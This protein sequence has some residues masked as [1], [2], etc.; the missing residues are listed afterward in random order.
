MLLSCAEKTA[1]Q[2]KDSTATLSKEEVIKTAREAYIYSLPLVL[3][4][5]TRKQGTNYYPANRAYAPVNSFKHLSE[6]PDASFKAVVRP[7]ADTYYSS[8]ILDLSKE[9]VVLSVPDTKGRY[10]MMPM[11]DAYTN[12]FASPGKRTTGDQAG[13]YLITGPKWN[14]AVPEGMTQIAAPT[15]LVWIIGRTQVNSKEDGKNVVVPLQQNYA[16]VPL[17]YWGKDYDPIQVVEDPGIP[18]EDP[19]TVVSRMSVEEYF[20]YVNSLL[21]TYPAPAA[22]N[23][24]LKRF[25][26]IGVGAGLKFNLDAF[27]DSTKVALKN[28]PLEIFTGLKVSVTQP[29]DSLLVNGWL[30]HRG[31]GSYGTDY[32]KRAMVA[33]MGLG[34]NLPED[35]LYSSCA[36]DEDKNLLNGANNY[37]LH[38]EKGKT[39]PVNAFWSL[40]MYSPDGYFIENPINRYTLGDRSNLKINADGSIDLY[41]QNTSPGKAKESNWLPAPKGEFNVLLRLYWPKEEVINGQWNAPVIKKVK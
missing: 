40:T 11:L 30:M 12:V 15:D 4:D 19:N 21:G 7:N 25:A 38:F 37:V 28:V 22:D 23:E 32:M 26:G 5:I 27:D 34:A 1:E 16:L 20:A 6:F 31:L 10:Y 17:S 13:N 2:G 39:P 41:I 36:I 29:K 14:G 8:A 3:M 35:A 24:V 33:Y 9:P 18:R